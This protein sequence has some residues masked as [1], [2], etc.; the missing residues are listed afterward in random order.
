MALKLNLTR[1]DILQGKVVPPGWYLCNI[2]DVTQ[3]KAKSSDSWNY[4]LYFS[5]A[6]GPHKDV[7]LKF[8][9]S[10]KAPGVVAP[11][12]E[13]FTGKEMQAGVDYDL[14][15]M[16]GKQIRVNVKNDEYNGR[17][18]NKVDGFKAA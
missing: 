8:W 5:I 17:L 2:K 9:I 3:E 11:L 1:E 18:T 7:P 4:V 12:I 14:E 6:D 15:S 10:E 13:I 16:K